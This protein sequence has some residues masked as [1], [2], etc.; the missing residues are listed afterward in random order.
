MVEE[1]TE[2]ETV[3]MAQDWALIGRKHPYIWVGLVDGRGGVYSQLYALLT[4]MK[5]K[6]LDTPCTICA[7]S[8]AA[9]TAHPALY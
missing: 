7:I 2:Q 6:Y 3:S 4:N 8:N 9:E 1:L 5:S